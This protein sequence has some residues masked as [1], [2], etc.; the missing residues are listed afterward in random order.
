MT[1]ILA[2]KIDENSIKKAL[3]KGKTVIWYKNELIGLEENVL[4]LVNSYLKII[5][6][7]FKAKTNVLVVDIKNTSDVKFVLKVNDGTS[8]ENGASIFNI[9][10]NT[11][12]SIEVGNSL[13]K[14]VNIGVDVLNAYIK[15][16]THP[17]TILTNH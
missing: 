17:S 9:L 6:T 1:L 13:S 4:H 14:K 7:S 12:T 16:N 5:N 10:P 8:I 2:D 3:F 15:P 11:I